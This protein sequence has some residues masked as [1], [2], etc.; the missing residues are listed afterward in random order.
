M[1]H[2]FDLRVYYEDTDAGGIVYYANY[3][4]FIERAR[5]EWV[6]GLGLDQA[7]LR[8]A[9]QMFAV[10]RLVAEYLAPA[11][12]DDLLRVETAVQTVSGARITLRQAVWRGAE[13]LFAAEVVLV[14]LTLAGRA[15]R[16]PPALRAAADRVG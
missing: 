6:R 11:R 14:C 4:K 9:G 13:Q 15:V 5:T 1:E 12:L 10:R 7:A 8:A 3:L 2:S 16:L